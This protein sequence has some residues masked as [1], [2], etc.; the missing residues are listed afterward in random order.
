WTPAGVSVHRFHQDRLRARGATEDLDREYR[1]APN[2]AIGTYLRGRA[3]S[4]SKEALERYRV[5][6]S[7]DASLPWPWLDT[8]EELLEAGEADEALA[9]FQKFA[10]LRRGATHRPCDELW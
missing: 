8:G 10:R 1:L 6:S 9:C 7:M 2:D 3:A 5:A 4:S